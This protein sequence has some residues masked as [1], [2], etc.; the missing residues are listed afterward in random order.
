MAW[1]TP[2]QDWAN[3]YEPTY[4]DFNR[5]E[6]N[7]DY[8]RSQAATF[9]GIKTF[10]GLTANSTV[11]ITNTTSGRVETLLKQGA[12]TNYWN[13]G[14]NGSGDYKITTNASGN[15][16]TGEVFGIDKTSRFITM[17]S[18]TTISNALAGNALTL[19]QN[20]DDYV[21]AN[22]TSTGALGKN[23]GLYIK[24]GSNST[25]YAL[26]I[27]D[28]DGGSIAKYQTTGIT[29]D[30]ALT[31]SA[32]TSPLL[33]D[34]GGGTVNMTLTNSG[35]SS[36]NTFIQQNTNP[37]TSGRVETLLHQDSQTGYWNIGLDSTGNYKL[38]TNTSGNMSSGVVFEIDKTTREF[39][40]SSNINPTT[41]PTE[42]V[43]TFTNDGDTFTISTRGLFCITLEIT[44]TAGAI[45]AMQLILERKINSI[46]TTHTKVIAASGAVNTDYNGTTIPSTGSNFRIRLYTTNE[47]YTTAKASILKT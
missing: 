34:G 24:A 15:M 26:S 30:K 46:W 5:I 36:N 37:T 19:S 12:Q 47:S 1:I 13:I 20:T 22:M 10:D 14:L 17:S 31:I 25:D 33:M 23:Y 4:G 18:P 8:I 41:T 29:F 7:I 42:S 2:K 9:Y 3:L 11:V 6:G 43:E 40:F 28:K 35:L 32:A 21:C 27:V 45:G 39:N 38:T 44:N 16:D